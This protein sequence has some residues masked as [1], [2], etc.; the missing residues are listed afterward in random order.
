MLQHVS[1]EFLFSLLVQSFFPEAIFIA[2]A[3]L[4]VVFHGTYVHIVHTNAKSA[5]LQLLFLFLLFLLNFCIYFNLIPSNLTVDL[6]TVI[7]AV[8]A[9]MSRRRF[10][11]GLATA[12]VTKL[13]RHA[14]LTQTSHK[15]NCCCVGSKVSFGF[16]APLQ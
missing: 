9:P 11:L 2:G 13:I 3:N 8:Y 4:V 7:A 12:Q 5:A 6:S 14:M 15:H 1:A 16:E 10:L